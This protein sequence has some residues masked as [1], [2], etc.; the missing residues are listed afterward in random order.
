MLMMLRRVSEGPLHRDAQTQAVPHTEARALIIEGLRHME[1]GKQK[2]KQA[3]D[4]LPG[5]KTT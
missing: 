2:L 5:A 3:L 1:A 4:R